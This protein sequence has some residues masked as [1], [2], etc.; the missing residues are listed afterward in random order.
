MTRIYRRT[1]RIEI[2]VRDIVVKI[3]PL[4]VHQKTEIQQAMLNGARNSDIKEKTRGTLLA[5]KYAVKDIQGVQESDGSPYVLSFEGEFLTDDCVN[6]LFNLEIARELTMV[7]A[8][9][10][11]GIPSEFTDQF[12]NKIEGVEFVKKESDSKNV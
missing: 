8:G 11:N 6:D 7:C 5:L 2:K 4:T 12:G 10:I 9:L 1:D 3:A